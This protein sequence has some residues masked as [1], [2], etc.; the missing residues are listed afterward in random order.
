MTTSRHSDDGRQPVGPSSATL[1]ILTSFLWGG[2][3]VAIKYSQDVLPPIGVAAARFLLA[4]GFMIL[5]CRVQRVGLGLERGQHRPAL[6]CG[7]LLYVQ[8]SLFHLGLHYSSPS[9]GSLL[10]NT[11]VL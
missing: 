9:H 10:I 11:F 4:A 3:P 6:I 5:W 2:T 8:I 7:L 1:A